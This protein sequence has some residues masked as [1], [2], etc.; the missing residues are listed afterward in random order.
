MKPTL[1]VTGEEDVVAG[2]ASLKS[3][4]GAMTETYRKV[5]GPLVPE[6]RARTPVRTGALGVSFTLGASKDGASIESPL[7]HALPIEY[8]TRRGVR[9]YRMV[10]DTLERNEGAIVEGIEADLAERARA[11]GFRVER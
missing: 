10:R 6:V 4:L 7:E 3:E 1:V 8:G 5:V 9:P 11:I 2:F